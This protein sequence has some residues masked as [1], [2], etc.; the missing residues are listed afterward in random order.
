MKRV[1][2]KGSKLNGGRKNKLVGNVV[3]EVMIA[4]KQEVPQ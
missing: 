4:L 1:L 2:S 3:M